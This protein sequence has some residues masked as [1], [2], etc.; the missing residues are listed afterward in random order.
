MIM[1]DSIRPSVRERT[2]LP[3]FGLPTLGQINSSLVTQPLTRMKTVIFISPNENNISLASRNS[4]FT[5]RQSFFIASGSLCIQ[6]RNGHWFNTLPNMCTQ[7]LLRNVGLS[8][9]ITCSSVSPVV[10]CTSHTK[11]K[12]LRIR[13]RLNNI[14]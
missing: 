1:R 3:K 14:E 5:R 10:A 7:S 6:I 11:F 9:S 13:T 12:Y 4:D 2:D 8:F